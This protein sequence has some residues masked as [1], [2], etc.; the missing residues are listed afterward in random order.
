MYI[1]ICILIIELSN[2]SI[3]NKM[4]FLFFIVDFILVEFSITCDLRE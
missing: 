3:N 2:F 1:C 4:L